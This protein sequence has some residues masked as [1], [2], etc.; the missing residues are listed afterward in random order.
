[1]PSLTSLGPEAAQHK[2]GKVAHSGLSANRPVH[3]PRHAGEDDHSVHG[4]DE[5]AGG[6]VRVAVFSQDELDG[7][8]DSL[9]NLPGAIHKFNTPLPIFSHMLVVAQ[10]SP[11]SIQ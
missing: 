7:I 6:Q 4:R 8:A 1:M 5:N 11:T 2:I 10:Q 3:A 9:N